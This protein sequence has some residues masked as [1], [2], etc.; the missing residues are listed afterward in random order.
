MYHFVGALNDL[1]QSIS[2]D[3][4]HALSYL[5]RA[6]CHKMMSFPEEAIQDYRIAIPMLT[7]ELEE[8]ENEK[9]LSVS[10]GSEKNSNNQNNKNSSNHHEM[11]RSKWGRVQEKMLQSHRHF[12]LSQ[13]RN[14]YIADEEKLTTYHQMSSIPNQHSLDKYE[15]YRIIGHPN[16]TMYIA[17]SGL[18][19][20][21]LASIREL[22][23]YGY[24]KGICI[25]TRVSETRAGI[26]SRVCVGGKFKCMDD[27]HIRTHSRVVCR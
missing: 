7:K 27:V 3:P 17:E 16:A 25:G 14:K 2:I 19:A 26:S 6:E 12:S 20:Q 13:Q 9:K 23:E 10:K 8:A 11:F 18:S 1:D 24:D 22:C 21:D 15:H 5:Y 4:S